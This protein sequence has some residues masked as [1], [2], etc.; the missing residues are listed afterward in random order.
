MN[1]LFLFHN[2]YYVSS[3]CAVTVVNVI[4]IYCND[5]LRFVCLDKTRA[6]CLGDFSHTFM[7]VSQD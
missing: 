7:F 5:I 3:D 2:I 4:N 1:L 6:T